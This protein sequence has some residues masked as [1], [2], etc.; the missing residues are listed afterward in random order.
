LF[1]E[2][3]INPIES[4]LAG[5]PWVSVTA[6]GGASTVAGCRWVKAFPAAALGTAWFQAIRGP[7]PDL[8][9]VATGGLT[10][11]SAPAFLEAGA[12]VVALGAAL[13]DP[14]QRQRLS[15]LVTPASD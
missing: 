14:A 13:T 15:R 4:N 10:V 8:H 9:Y 6:S 7:F 3:T 11:Q 2:A 12:R 1:G 5:K